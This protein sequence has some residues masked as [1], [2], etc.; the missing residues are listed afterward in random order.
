MLRDRL[1]RVRRL[2]P[3]HRLRWLAAPLVLA[4]A[5]CGSSD[6]PILGRLPVFPVKGEV[7]FN[8]QPPV[9]ASVVLHPKGIT[10]PNPVRPYGQVGQDGKFT[11]TSYDAKDGAPAGQYL[12]TLEWRKLVTTDAGVSAGPNVLPI[13]YRQPETSPISVKINEADNELPVIQIGKR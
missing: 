6:T 5:G 1:L 10:S 7:Q 11:L 13:E 3:R 12:V 2:S 9:G 4:A 8:G